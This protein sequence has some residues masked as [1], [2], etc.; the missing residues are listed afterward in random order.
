MRIF[1][2]R[3]ISTGGG[4]EF[5]NGLASRGIALYCVPHS[6]GHTIRASGYSEWSVGC[7]RQFKI[8]G[9]GCAQF[10]IFFALVAGTVYGQSASSAL[11]PVASEYGFTPCR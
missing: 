11:E 4:L 7:L 10:A 5:E 2:F 6:P 3:G 9:M 1:E 8:T